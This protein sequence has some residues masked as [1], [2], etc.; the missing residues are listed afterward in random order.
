LEDQSEEV[1]ELV[2]GDGVGAV[3][4][5]L[6]EAVARDGVGLLAGFV[7]H[8]RGGKIRWMMKYRFYWLFNSY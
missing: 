4:V 6:V 1:V 2:D 7:A 5:R 8:W 3:E